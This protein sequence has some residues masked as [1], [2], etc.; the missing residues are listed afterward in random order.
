[1]RKLLNTDNDLKCPA[2]TA[3]AFKAL[4]TKGFAGRQLV[5]M[6]FGFPAAVAF[7]KSERKNTGDREIIYK[8]SKCGNKW[9]V[10]PGKTAESDRLEA[11]C[12]IHFTRKSSMLGGAM[13]QFVYLNGKK[14]G[15]VKNGGRITFTTERKHNLVFVTDHLGRAFDTRHFDARAGE[16]IE[17]KF[18]RKFL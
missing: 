10:L 4:G 17:L 11:L 15:P 6:L 12:E 9:T 2:C 1:M 5:T 3:V 8:C 18:K 7:S 16:Q 13:A 14:I